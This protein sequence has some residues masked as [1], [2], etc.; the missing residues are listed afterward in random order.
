MHKPRET[1]EQGFTLSS[2]LACLEGTGIVQFPGWATWLMKLGVW[3]ARTAN[4]GHLVRVAVS[5]PHRGF[6][7]VFAALG[8][9]A[10]TYRSSLHTDPNDRLEYFS[11]LA[12]GTPVRYRL[13][14]ST[15]R[16]ECAEF[17]SVEPVAGTPYIRLSARTLNYIREMSRFRFIEPLPSGIPAPARS[18]TICKA[19]SFVESAT[20]QDP[21]EHGFSTRLECVM[22]GTK[23]VLESELQ[24]ELVAGGERGILQDLWRCSELLNPA[25]GYRSR[26]VSAYSEPDSEMVDRPEGGAV[27][28]GPSAI[29]Y[30]H[31]VSDRPWIALIDRTHRRAMDARDAILVDRASSLEDIDLPIGYPPPGVEALGF[32][33]PLP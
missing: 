31:L 11:S 21:I 5:V 13:G 24:I 33:D 8:I 7:A 4:S 22:I 6:A 20:G 28:D 30:R 17:V 19:P 3:V 26:I 15:D 18:R 2:D 23:I 12:P 29:M 14:D 16:Y 25:D 10:G 9:A 32:I 27:L 1:A